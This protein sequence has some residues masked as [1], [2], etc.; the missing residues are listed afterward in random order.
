MNVLLPLCVLLPMA[1]SPVVYAVGKRSDKARDRVLWCA[2]LCEAALCVLLAA[3]GDAVWALQGS[4]LFGVRLVSGGL[5]SVLAVLCAAVFVCSALASPAYFA[6]EARTHR[7]YAFM[8]LTFGATEGVFLSGDFLT[9]FFFFEIMSMASWVWVAQNETP[10]SE[11]AANTYL[12]IAVLGGL[13]LLGGMLAVYAATGGVLQFD[14]LQEQLAP[15]AKSPL[16]FAGVLLMTLGFGAKAGMFPL[17]IWLP[18]AHPAAP[19]PASALL[20]GILIKS[21]VF[22]ILL[23]IVCL[24]Q[25]DARYALLLLAAGVVTMLLGALMA[26]TATDLKR[27]LACSS[28]SQIGF[29]LVAA[30]LLAFGQETVL[31]AGGAVLHTVNHALIKT[32]LFLSAGVLYR[33]FHTLDL[34]A[35]RGAGRGSRLLAVCFFIAGLSVA[36]VPLFGGYISKT[37]I[38]EAIVEQMALAS[39]AMHA[40]LR[41]VEI[42]FL[43]T[44]GLTFAYMCKLFALLFV[45]KRPPEAAPQTLF[46]GRASGAA[47]AVPALCLLVTGVFPAATYE[48]LAAYAA[49]S[50]GSEAFS[51]SYFSLQNL[52]GAAISLLIGAVV[53][54]FGIRVFCMRDGRLLERKARFSL[55]DNVYRPLLRALSFVGALA[56]RLAYCLT[57][58]FV[59]ALRRL[60]GLGAQ[61]RFTPPEDS[62]FAHGAPRRAGL[63][64]IS[65]TLAFELMLFGIG[66]VMTLL[67]LLF[68]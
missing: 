5:Q 60:N 50:L 68:A 66:A 6:G 67:Y 61:R 44:G 54:R 18:K 32:V 42:L 23:C 36:G 35:L 19:A 40:L 34:N 48:K 1:A 47:L 11:R 43:C 4:A 56:A 13:L 37:L 57:E 12:A 49:A 52:R 9:L 28:L 41:V 64:A 31:A 63:G 26:L 2:A 65:Q 10:D 21:G 14:A 20:S 33:N 7:Y 25:G 51:L 24:M 29:I 39:G 16:L 30:A 27:V 62:T 45:Q 17:H 38:H 55:E 3:A 8:L 53:Y 59:A 58:W 15:G 22:G 46:L